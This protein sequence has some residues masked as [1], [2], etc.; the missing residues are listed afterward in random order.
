LYVADA[1]VTD[2]SSVGFEYMLLDRPIVVVDCP[3]LAEKARINP[4]KVSLLQSSA[5]VAHDAAS[6]R[7]AV[8]RALRDPERHGA[9]RRS[10]A[11]ELFHR[12]GTATRRAV[13]CIY[14]LL[15]LSSPATPQH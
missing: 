12:P 10:V 13:E 2:H 5:D 15:A 14:D 1:L 4:Q 3:E 9:R 11:T 8:M 7:T 6:L